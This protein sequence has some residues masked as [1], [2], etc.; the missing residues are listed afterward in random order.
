MPGKKFKSL[1]VLLLA[2]ATTAVLLAA[3]FMSRNWVLFAT[4]ILAAALFFCY[5]G[6]E[7]SPVVSAREIGLIA[8]LVQS[9]PSAGCPLQPSPASSQSPLWWW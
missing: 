7:A 5:L 3:G 6:F 4:A 2:A 1:A 8:V 9:P